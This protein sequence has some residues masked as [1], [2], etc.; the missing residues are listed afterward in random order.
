MR[1]SSRKHLT[2]LAMHAART[3]LAPN[4]IP[5]GGDGSFP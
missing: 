5:P 2:E 3:E 4:S 1:H